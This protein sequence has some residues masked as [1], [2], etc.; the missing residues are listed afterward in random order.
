MSRFLSVP[1]AGKTYW[2]VLTNPILGASAWQLSNA[3]RSEG[4]LVS[5][6]AL[7]GNLVKDGASQPFKGDHTIRPLPQ[8][9]GMAGKCSIQSNCFE[10]CD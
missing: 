6:C 9:K 8:S 7:T 10:P 4:A 5:T 2:Y 1:F 3:R